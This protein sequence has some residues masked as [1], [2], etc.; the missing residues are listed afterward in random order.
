[1]GYKAGMKEEIE[2]IGDFTLHVVQGALKAKNSGS[3]K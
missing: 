2:K 3:E 1:M